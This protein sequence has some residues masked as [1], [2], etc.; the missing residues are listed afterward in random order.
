MIAHGIF[1]LCVEGLRLMSGMS[2]VADMAQID[3]M[4][5]WR[6]EFL[7]LVIG[8]LLGLTYVYLC[9]KTVSNPASN[10]LLA[11]KLQTSSGETE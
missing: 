9:S 10:F 5:Y 2:L 1:N 7:L 3:K 6:F 4:F 11:K 8:L